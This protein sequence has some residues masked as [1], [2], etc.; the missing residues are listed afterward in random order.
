MKS[1]THL[2]IALE[3]VGVIGIIAGISVE[4]TMHADLGYIIISSGCAMVASGALI[5]GKLIKKR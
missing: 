4:V 1:V 3:A 5:W 2:A